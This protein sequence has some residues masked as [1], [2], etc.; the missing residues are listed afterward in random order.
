M[1]C[2]SRLA[3]LPTPNFFS[4]PPP[5]THT[6]THT[7]THKRA[8]RYHMH[9]HTCSRTRTH[10]HIHT[11]V[12]TA[13]F[14]LCFAQPS[15]TAHAPVTSPSETTAGRVPHS[16]TTA[17]K[18]VSVTHSDQVIIP[19]PLLPLLSTLTT[20]NL[21]KTQQFAS[22]WTNCTEAFRSRSVPSHTTSHS[23]GLGSANNTGDLSEHERF[24]DTRSE[25]GKIH[26][27]T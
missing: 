23:A 26:S 9:T 11:L 10:T 6:H 4:T 3:A 5:N 1:G 14:K 13:C 19:P 22:Q 25:Q 17:W 16:L 7:N 20:T 24:R 21:F 27:T 15:F 2:S 18:S 8:Y 12:H